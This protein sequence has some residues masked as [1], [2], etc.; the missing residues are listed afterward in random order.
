MKH[1]NGG[2]MKNGMMEQWNNGVMGKN[3]NE[4]FSFGLTQH[5]NIPLFQYSN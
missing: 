2:R 3:K 5:S 1:W 4:S